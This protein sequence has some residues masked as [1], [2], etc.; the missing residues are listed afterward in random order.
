MFIFKY[1]RLIL[2][3]FSLQFLPLKT[4]AQTE[5]EPLKEHICPQDLDKAIAPILQKPQ[6]AGA[7]WGIS[8]QTLGSD[9]TVYTFNADKYFIPAS[10]L[11]LLTTAAALLELGHNFQISTPVY[12]TG[13][14]PHLTSLR[15]IGRGDPTISSNSL[16]EIVQELE[17]Q[18]V[19]SIEKLIVEDSYFSTPRINPT[20]EWSDLYSYYATS[21]SSLVLNQNTIA[22]TLLPQQLGQPVKYR[23]SNPVSSRQWQIR[24]Q[25]ITAPAQTTYDISIEP[26]LGQ[27][28]LQIRGQ[29]AIDAEPDIWDLAVV[30]PAYHF[31]ESFRLTL[32]TRGISVTQGIVN[33]SPSRQTEA[34]KILKLTSPTLPILLAEINQESNNLY[35]EILLKILAKEL[36]INS[37]REAISES[38]KKLGINPQKYHLVDGSGLSRHNLITPETIVEVLKLMRQTSVGKI[39][40]TSLSV[41]GV[42]GTLSRRF[43]NTIVQGKLW[44]K[45]GTLTGVAALSG[46][47]DVPGYQPLVFSIIVNNANA[48]GVTLRRTIDE[49]V[50]SLGKLSF[51]QATYLE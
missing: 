6:L 30:D 35:A 3:L 34:Q 45:T 33:N 26:V 17:Q 16:K 31:L 49:I 40:Q 28:V 7:N 47:L 50:L 25:A 4:V 23:W 14:P 51:C 46:Y 19:K 18:G 48:P 29:L 41:A 9:H 36:N 20:W 37:E 5:T 15:I 43:S 2:L 1:W 22:L 39:Y 21:V 27:P 13:K 10:N 38:L 42:K 12:I 24:N 8:V 11:K 32:L 44:G